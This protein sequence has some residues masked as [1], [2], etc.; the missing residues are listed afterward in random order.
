MEAAASKIRYGSCASLLSHNLS[1][2]IARQSSRHLYLRPRAPTQAVAK[3]IWFSGATPKNA[4]HL[5]V[6]NL[7]RIRE[8]VPQF[9]NWSHL[10][11]WASSFTSLTPSVMRMMVVQALTYTI[12]QQRNNM[13]HNQTLLPPLV[14][15]NGI[16]RHIIDYLCGKEAEKIQLPYGTLAI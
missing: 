10:M 2:T 8:P 6:T 5:W 1:Y 7:N 3:Y 16:N 9:S 15:F 14:A 13:L 11:Q 12:W 4:F